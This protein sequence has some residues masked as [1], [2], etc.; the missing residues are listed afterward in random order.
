[1]PVPRFTYLDLLL[2]ALDYRLPP[3]PWRW[4]GDSTYSIYLVHFPLIVT[5]VIV[6]RL[7]GLPSATSSLFLAAYVGAVLLIAVPTYRRFELP[8]QN[9]IRDRWRAKE[10]TCSPASSAG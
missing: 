6:D 1:M 5:V 7:I 4:I 3:A 9:W 10:A 8:A 2:A